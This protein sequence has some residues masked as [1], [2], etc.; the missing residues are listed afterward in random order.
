MSPKKWH[1]LRLTLEAAKDVIT[2][3]MRAVLKTKAENMYTA[4]CILLATQSQISFDC[5][6]S[7]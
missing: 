7:R 1:E 5:H 4:V 3:D 2:R 6:Q